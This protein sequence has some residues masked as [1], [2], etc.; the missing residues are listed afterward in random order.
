[1][2]TTSNS[3]SPVNRL[4]MQVPI[5][6]EHTPFDLKEAYEKILHS[7]L[8]NALVELVESDHILLDNQRQACYRYTIAP[9][10]ARHRSPAGLQFN[11]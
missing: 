1:M 5:M 11:Y 8:L 10:T 3:I 2:R 4:G 9:A 7:V 6:A